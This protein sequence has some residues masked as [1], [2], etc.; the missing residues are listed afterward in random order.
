MDD[1]TRKL[2]RNS[3]TEFLIFAVGAGDETI[4]A[5]NKD[6]TKWLSQKLMAELFGVGVN[7]LNGELTN[8]RT[9]RKFRIVQ[10]KGDRKVTRDVEFFNL[11]AI[12]SVGYRANSIR[13]TQF[14]HW[15]M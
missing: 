5:R 8:D 12:I 7:T 13:A 15:A 2:I 10:Q 9:I 1:P 4:E 6:D 14:R 3:T 11:D